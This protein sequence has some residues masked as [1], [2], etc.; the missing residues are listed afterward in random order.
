M[1][2]MQKC[3]CLYVYSVLIA[4]WAMKSAQSC[5]CQV[6]WSSNTHRF[7]LLWYRFI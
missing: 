4:A 6:H 2:Q 5:V 7:R 1:V 3:L